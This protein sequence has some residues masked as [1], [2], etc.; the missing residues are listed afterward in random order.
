VSGADGA[1]SHVLFVHG[2]SRVHELRPQCKLA[3]TMV[4]IFAVVVTPRDAFWAF[5]AY[6]LL[7]AGVARSGKVPIRL[8]ARRLRFEAPFVAFAVFLPLIGQGRRIDVLGVP[9]SVAG[10]WGAWNIV[11][12]GTFGVAATALLGATTSVS[13]LLVGLERLRVPR[14]FVAITGSM[15]RYAEVITGEMRRMKIARQSRGYEPRWMWQ[16]KAVA[17][18]AGAL[19]VRSYERGERVYLAMA[20][21]GYD[22][23]LPALDEYT[24]SRL[25][26]LTAMV[27]PA[28]AT[29]TAVVAIGLAA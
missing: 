29:V 21:R 17:S 3:A 19:F 6:A 14:V 10:L 13:E 4:F 7:I 26:W 9:L 27:V 22:G 16:S 15:M 11:I 5:A 8:L 25:E 2:E 1:H 28:I 12:K 18:S 20:S 24:A 23:S